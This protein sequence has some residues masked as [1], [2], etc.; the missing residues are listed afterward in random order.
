MDFLS[1]LLSCNEEDVNR[2]VD[3]ELNDLLNNCEKKQY[4]GFI[5]GD[6]SLHEAHKGFIDFD[7]R[8]RFGVASTLNYSMKTKDFYYAFAHDVK[9]YN[10]QNIR[11]V[12]VFLMFFINSYLGICTGE[13]RREYIQNI[14]LEST[15]T[16]EEYF[17]AIEALEIGYFKGKRMGMCTERSAIAQNILSMFGVESYYCMGAIDNKPHCFNVIKYDGSFCVLDYSQLCSFKNGEKSYYVPLLSKIP[18]DNADDFFNKCVPM[19]LDAYNY[20]N[21][22]SVKAGQSDYVVGKWE[23]EIEK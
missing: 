17:S 16:D 1:K 11:S 8:I 21:G 2:I 20:V 7:T 15:V 19:T 23:F 22:E 6:R 18:D 13:D 3:E 14:L 4:L 10:I 12:I 9:R 5:P